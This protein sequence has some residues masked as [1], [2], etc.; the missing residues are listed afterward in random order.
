MRPKSA[1]QGFERLPAGRR[2]PVAEA[3]R[4]PISRDYA[5]S[6]TLIAPSASRRSMKGSAVVVIGVDR[7]GTKLPWRR[8]RPD[9]HHDYSDEGTPGSFSPRINRLLAVSRP[10]IALT[11]SVALANPKTG[12]LP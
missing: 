2:V 7:V 3:T 12:M 4:C 10:P 1:G 8:R 11:C 9:P 6:C 5:T